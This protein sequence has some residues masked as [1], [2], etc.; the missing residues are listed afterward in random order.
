MVVLVAELAVVLMTGKAAMV[1]FMS[2]ST[3]SVTARAEVVAQ[4]FLDVVV[5]EERRAL[6]DLV[7]VTEIEVLHVIEVTSLTVDI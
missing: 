6:E 3:M 5:T 7:E 2:H 1:V 4:E